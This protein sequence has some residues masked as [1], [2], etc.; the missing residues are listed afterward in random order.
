[1]GVRDLLPDGRRRFFVANL[2][3]K[4]ANASRSDASLKGESG[5][6]RGDRISAKPAPRSPVRAKGVSIA[7]GKAGAVMFSGTRPPRVELPT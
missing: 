4:M 6:G 5:V 3:M 7:R 2:E 1:V